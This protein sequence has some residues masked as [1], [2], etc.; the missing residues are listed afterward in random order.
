MSAYGE[1]NEGRLLGKCRVITGPVFVETGDDAVA[2]LRNV[3]VEPFLGGSYPVLLFFQ[4]F[5]IRAYLIPEVEV[6]VSERFLHAAII[7]PIP[8]HPE[9]SEKHLF[10]ASILTLY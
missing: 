7:H 1:G 5:G 9:C 8:I 2:S 3:F 10:V 4:R 6:A